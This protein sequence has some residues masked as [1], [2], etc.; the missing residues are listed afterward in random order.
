MSRTLLALQESAHDDAIVEAYLTAAL[1]ASHEDAL[2]N[3]LE[4]LI[5][6]VTEVPRLFR[7][8]APQTLTYVLQLVA[9]RKGGVR[10][11]AVEFVVS[12][13][14]SV[15]SY[16]ISLFEMRTMCE[17]RY[18]MPPAPPTSIVAPPAHSMRFDEIFYSNLRSNNS[19]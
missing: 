4:A 1:D 18:G 12:I 11:L 14:Y 2:L 19:T 9:T 7:S 3:G 10:A 13:V 15:P 17:L 6:L 5:D 8:K 16:L